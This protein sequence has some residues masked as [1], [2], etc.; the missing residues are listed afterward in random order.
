MNIYIARQPIYDTER[1][2]FGY[3]FL[4]R[5]SHVNSFN[6]DIDGSAA[7]RTLISNLVN[8]FG[9]ET[10]TGGRYAFVNFTRELL[11][12]H[13]PF[14]LDNTRF[15]IEILEN[16]ILDQNMLKRLQNLKAKGYKVALDDYVGGAEEE[17]LESIEILKVDFILTTPPERKEI[18]RRYRGR[19]NLL[20]EKVET[21]EEFNSAVGMGYTLFQGYYF[22]KPVPFS[23]PVTQVAADTCSLLWDEMRRPSPRFDKLA[24]IISKDVDL[25]Y[26]FLTKAST[27]KYYRGDRVTNIHN[28]L[29]RIGL[30]EIRRWVIM[31]LVNDITGKGNSDRTKLALVR[32]CFGEKLMAKTSHKNL[33][34]EAYLAGMFSVIEADIQ[35]DL[36]LLLEKLDISPQVSGALLDQPGFL[37]DLLHFIY[38]YEAGEWDHVSAFINQTGLDEKWV[39]NQYMKSI[40]YAEQA[41]SA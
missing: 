18:A 29:M 10:M 6:P 14:L 15:I 12:T 3:E 8:E 7:T 25:M 40:S 2:L 17:Q 34:E 36:I 20:A 21:E 23:K 19:I 1:R 35:S 28:A 31:I 37:T 5:D 38:S 4:Y 22:S 13:F 41:F 16:V 30:M 33:T 24:A 32:G 11:M 39:V 27:L 26:K 9:V